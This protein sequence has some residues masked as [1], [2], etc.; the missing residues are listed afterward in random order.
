MVGV[1]GS[2]GERCGAATP[3]AITLPARTCGATVEASPNNPSICPPIKSGRLSL[4]LRNG[5]C[6]SLTP[7]SR[8]NSSDPRCDTVPMPAE[9]IVTLLRIGFCIGDEFGHAS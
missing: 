7:A 8:C 3:I 6:T 4:V 1:S 2:A 5:T 9:P